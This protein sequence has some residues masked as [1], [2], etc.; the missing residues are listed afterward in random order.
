MLIVSEG[1]AFQLC[2]TLWVKK[3]FL[4][5]G[6]LVVLRVFL[7]LNSCHVDQVGSGKVLRANAV[8]DTNRHHLSGLDPGSE[9]AD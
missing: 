2:T 9:E 3:R 8:A 1:S 6:V 7:G 5:S 4:T